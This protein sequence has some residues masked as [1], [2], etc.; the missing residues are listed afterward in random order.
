MKKKTFQTITLFLIAICIGVVC[1]LAQQAGF[2]SEP[3]SITLSILGGM[4]IGAIVSCVWL[5]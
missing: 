1:N 4:L 2:L 5:E 3:F